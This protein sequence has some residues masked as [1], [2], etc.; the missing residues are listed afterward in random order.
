M[1]KEYVAAVVKAWEECEAAHAVEKAVQ[2]EAIKTDGLEDPVVRLLHVTC[3]AA[4]TQC[5]QAV[6]VSLTA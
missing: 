1:T 4:R 3:K 5:N 2:K 6:D